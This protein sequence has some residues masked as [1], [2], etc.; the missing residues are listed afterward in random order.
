MLD[1]IPLDCS[2]GEMSWSFTIPGRLGKSVEHSELFFQTQTWI[3]FPLD[4]KEAPID[5]MMI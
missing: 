1:A 3:Y 5:G 2:D 4:T